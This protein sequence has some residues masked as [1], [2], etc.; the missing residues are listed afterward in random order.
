[1]TTETVLLVAL[2]ALAAWPV[3]RLFHPAQRT[4]RGMALGLTGMAIAVAC[5]F[6]LVGETEPP[7][8][9]EPETSG[10]TATRPGKRRTA[11]SRSTRS[12]RM[13]SSRP[14]RN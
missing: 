8:I 11:T 3:A 9:I 10:Q 1:M 2:A 5:G 7:Q 12:K 6:M 13:I 4:P 14:S